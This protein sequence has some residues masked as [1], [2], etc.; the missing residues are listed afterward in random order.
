M[1]SFSI[2]TS[3]L[4][5]FSILFSVIPGVVSATDT[6][7]EMEPVQKKYESGNIVRVLIVPGHDNEFSGAQFGSIIEADLALSLGK[8]IAEKLSSSPQFFVTITRNDEGY[9]P[10]LSDYFLSNEKEIYAFIKDKKKKTT[11]AIDSG[12]IIVEDQITHNDAPSA[13]AFRLYAINKWASENKYDLILHIHFNDYWP[14]AFN[15]QGEYGGF[16]IYT[17]DDMLPNGTVS[18]PFADAIGSRLKK[19]WYQSNLPIEKEFANENGVVPDFKLIA[20]GSN[21]TLTT[22]S[23]LVE[24]S[25]IYEPFI[26]SELFD[27][28]S[29]VMAEATTLGISEYVAKGVYDISSLSYEWTSLLSPSPKRKPDIIALQYALYEIGMYPP[30]SF[31]KE[32]CPLSGIFGPCTKA[33]VQQFQK[34]KQLMTSGVLTPSTR[35]ALNGLFQ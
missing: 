18:K 2:Q 12:K 33:A 28:T 19:T 11:R 17:P 21:M 35:T 20:L 26:G 3:K 10:E 32:K 6:V 1:K 30:A 14:R 7:I 24:Y 29:E 8:K 4:I 15:K 23:I 16:T 31:T 13:V 34:S 9:I 22:P 25:Y 27:L 5:V